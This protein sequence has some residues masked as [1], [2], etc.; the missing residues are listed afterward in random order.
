MQPTNDWKQ[1]P[2]KAVVR[3]VALQQFGHWMMG[4]ARIGNQSITMSGSY[5]ADG[6]SKTVPDEIYDN[7]GIDLPQELYDAWNHG[8]GWNSAGNEAPAMR[9]WAIDNFKDLAPVNAEF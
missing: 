9:E 3:K 2:L 4:V 6:L 5:G 8:G 1:K 7:Y